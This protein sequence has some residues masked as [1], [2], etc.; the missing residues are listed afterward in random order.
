MNIGFS[1]LSFLSLALLSM[2]FSALPRDGPATIVAATIL[3]PDSPSGWMCGLEPR[4]PGDE[5]LIDLLVRCHLCD[6]QLL[7]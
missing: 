1:Y 2:N 6:M 3:D 4:T 7:L 5:K